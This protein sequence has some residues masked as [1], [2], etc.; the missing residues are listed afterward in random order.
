MITIYDKSKTAHVIRPCPFINITWNSFTNSDGKVGGKYDIVLTGTLL[1]DDGSPVTG[2]KTARNKPTFNASYYPRPTKT[3]F[4][5]PDPYLD[6]LSSL[7]RKQWALTDLFAEEGLKV[8]VASV[9]KGETTPVITFYPNLVSIN[10]EEG[11]WVDRCNYSITLEAPFLL[12][13]S[14]NIIGVQN[15]LPKSKPITAPKNVDNFLIDAGGFVEDFQESWSIEPEE[16]AGITFDPDDGKDTITRVYRLTR[17][18]SAKGANIENYAKSEGLAASTAKACEQARKYVTEYILSSGQALNHSDDYP[19]LLYK[20]S[21]LFA[22]GLININKT[23]NWGYNHSRTENIDVAGGTYSVQDSWILTSGV[24][25]ENFSLSL[26]NSEENPRN[27][28]VIEGTIKGLSLIPGS[29]SVFAGNQDSTLNT[30][31]EN[32]INKYREITNSGQFGLN[33]WTF[34]RAN[35]A[36]GGVELNDTPLTVAVAANEFTGEINYTIEYDD[37]PRQLVSGVAF[38]NVSVSDTYPGDVFAVIPVIGRPTGPILQYIGGRTE[39][40]RN[41]SIEVVAMPNRFVKDDTTTTEVRARKDLVLKP[42]L[43][44]PSKESIADIIRSY[45]PGKEPGIRKYFVSPPQETWDPQQ[46]RYSLNITWTYEL[47]Y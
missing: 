35:R 40:Q 10:F 4:G 18:I 23:S 31:Y 12:D 27:K 26:T 41:L 11:F 30:A 3:N 33:A 2:D 22:S 28:V 25:T 38:S 19:T 39:Y 42:S 29:G 15:Y 45:S 46:G 5:D 21:D 36:A 34:K 8:E 47:N 13:A 24:A 6:A 32:A 20:G 44:S 7:L 17:N 9:R 1:Y 37:R 14:N 43:V 16:G